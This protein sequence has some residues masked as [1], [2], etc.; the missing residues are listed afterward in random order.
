MENANHFLESGP[1]SFKRIVSMGAMGGKVVSMP[2]V[3]FV[4]IIT[5]GI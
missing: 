3:C 1:E 2:A 4:W 5:N